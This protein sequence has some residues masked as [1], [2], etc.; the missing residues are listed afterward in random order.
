ML[1]VVCDQPRTSGAKGLVLRAAGRREDLTDWVGEST[2]GGASQR[3]RAGLGLVEQGSGRV[4]D[5]LRCLTDIDPDLGAAEQ[6]PQ[7]L[8]DLFEHG[9]SRLG[10]IG[11][12]ANAAHQRLGGEPDDRADRHRKQRR[13]VLAVRILGRADEHD[14][15]QVEHGQA[16]E[17]DHHAPAALG[18]KRG[19]EDRDQRQDSRSGGHAPGRVA[20][21]PDCGQKDQ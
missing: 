19:V 4:A 6:G 13:S 18:V 5:P 2:R 1:G 3:A 10:L 21:H 17:H 15:R 7:A 20:K 8:A 9:A 14:R 11:A 16:E 12:K